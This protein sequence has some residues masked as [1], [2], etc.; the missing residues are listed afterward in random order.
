[1]RGGEV[2]ETW[3][4][5]FTFHGFRYVDVEGWPGTLSAED[6][7]AIVVHSDMAR[8][9]WFE[10]S[11]DLV[12]KFHGNVVRSM[13][14]NF[15]GV[16][17]DCPQRDERMGWTGDL[18]AFAPS[19]AFLYDVRGVLRSW[20]EDLAAEQTEKGFVPWVVPDILT[21]PSAPT[22]LWSD[23]AISLPWVLYNEYGDL[24]IL[25]RSYPSMVSFMTQV[26]P[27]LDEDGLWS[28]GYQF[29]DWLDPDAPPENA[30][31]GKTDKH[32]VASAYLCK[33]T[34][35]LAATAGL[36]GEEDDAAH[37]SALAE[38]VRGRSAISTSPRQDE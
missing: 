38:R 28:K 5:R 15:V 16:P 32:L 24:E 31:A 26:E 25:R 27:L 35:E 7:R 4:P 3:E 1:M 8:S 22:A 17:T 18:N 9:G 29:G 11:N 34:R 13:R 37:F 6:I 12:T 21:H 33:T 2:P 23:V 10:T 20:L 19:A 30:A 36:L 14:G